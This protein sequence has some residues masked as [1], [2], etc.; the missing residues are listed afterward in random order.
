MSFF[1]RSDNAGEAFS[2]PRGLLY[3]CLAVF[4]FI[5]VYVEMVRFLELET[6]ERRS[7][8]YQLAGRELL[9]LSEYADDARFF[10]LVLKNE[11][12]AGALAMAP[13][14]QKLKSR[15]N[16]LKNE[17]PGVFSFIFWNSKGEVISELSDD[18][19]FNFLS[20]KL[21]QMLGAIRLDTRAGRH[22]E[23][24]FSERYNR[25]LRMLRQFLG[26]FVTP[27]G[28]IKPFVDAG[29]AACFQL[30]ARGER[31]LG[32]YES[33][34]DYSVLAYVSAKVRGALTGPKQLCK[35]LQ[36]KWPEMTF[37][38]FDEHELKLSPSPGGTTGSEILVNFG[39]FRKMAPKEHLASQRHYYE[40]QKLNERWWGVSA[41]NKN[42]VGS[43]ASLA[44]KF[45]A[46]AVAVVLIALFV[47]GCYFMVHEN[48][49]YSVRAKLVIV[50][51]YTIF[52]PALVFSVVAFDYLKQKEKQAV[53]EFSARSFQLL[54]SID[55]QFNGFLHDRAGELN[56]VFAE[57]SAGKAISDIENQIASVS[58]AIVARFAPDTLVIAD[59]SGKDILNA[60]YSKTL[61][62]DHLRKNAAGELI[63]YLNS[64]V[65]ELHRPSQGVAEGFLL[66]FPLNYRR[67][68]PF[69][70]SSTTFISYLNLLRSSDDSKFSH[71]VQI[72]WHE[73]DMHLEF[74]RQLTET[75]LNNERQRLF[76][77]FPATGKTWP[78]K[79][80]LPGLSD[81]LEKVRQ[82]GPSY[83]RLTG[84]D[85][86]TWLAV[87][88]GGTSLSS[89]ILAVLVD[90]DLL[91]G[92][93][94]RLKNRI[95][96]LV[97]WSILITV[98]LFY[99]LGHY[100]IMPIKAMAA[101]VEMVRKQNYSYRINMPLANEFGRL[102]HS[103]DESLEN[104][105]ELEIA[106]T[107]QESLLPQDSLDL[108][109]FFIIART[110]SM[111]SMGGD[112]YDFVVDRDK[113]AA[114][115]MADVAGHGIQAALLM[116]MAKST[117]LLN[118]SACAEPEIIMSA[119]NRTFCTLRKSSITTMMTG[120]IVSIS[121]AGE[122]NF[123]NAGH[124]PPLVVSDTGKEVTPV[125]SQALPFGFSLKRKFERMPVS[126]SAG[127]TMILY[128]DGI[129]ESSN[130]RG[131]MLGEDGFAELA[132]NCYDADCKCY[133]DK[134][135]SAY[136]NW[137]ASQ[138]DD[139]TFVMIRRKA[140]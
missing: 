21:N 12:S 93:I 68:L 130:L 91:Q 5:M 86:K 38:L 77:S 52:I 54:T 123:L 82:H 79:H 42:A 94:R 28:L 84:Q 114:I 8:L 50:F 20:K 137:A 78:Q 117:L 103:I 30:H 39:K 135:F 128:S 102:S 104:L 80:G 127:D 64:S 51:A 34:A 108:D 98:S 24:E 74:F 71:L 72:F 36:N 26:P 88:Q 1:S 23:A 65:R 27:E 136:D 89:S 126:L 97:G 3:I 2:L 113:N 53:S 67:L 33:T 100:L 32:W 110:R 55:S 16:R 11:F 92:D 35:S 4:P 41:I 75:T 76:I 111:T 18:T 66:S 115:L 25:D 44:G 132:K 31:T 60:L 87:G 61:K 58:K 29:S 121:C 107:V 95:W 62:D 139:I 90:H 22:V 7:E 15:V 73:K 46:K 124:C 37:Y 81:F 19:R 120:Q 112:Y 116:A 49:L 70:L 125:N 59:S 69:T 63:A 133:L 129:L 14:A 43:V 40:F 106:K 57:M 6:D 134:L 85:G 17:Y 96:S 83:E 9:K 118:D 109:E 99:I 48:P 101:G 105:Q 140:T 13:G 45:L 131:E 122:L 47:F 119:L 10:H 138:Q 56:S